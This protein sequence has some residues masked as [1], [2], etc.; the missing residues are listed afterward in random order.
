MYAGDV[1]M[2]FDDNIK[3]M[4]GWDL[5]DN[6]IKVRLTLERTDAARFVVLLRRN[7]DSAVLFPGLD[8]FSRSL[9]ERLPLYLDLA[10]RGVGTSA[11]TAE[12][13]L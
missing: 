11:F 5:A 10:R 4:H 9:G 6:V 12:S 8:G 1:S 7:V 13:S 2:R 3:A